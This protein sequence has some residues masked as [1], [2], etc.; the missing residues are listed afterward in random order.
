MD[1]R[2]ILDLYPLPLARGYRR[3]LNASEVKERHDL[4]FCLFEILLKYVAS[5]AIAAYLA[6]EERDH[7]VNAAL[8]G[9]MRPSL[10][11]W[12]RFLRECLEFLVKQE[13]ADPALRAMATLLKEK[14]SH[15]PHVV[16]LWNALRA[17][18]TGSASAKEAASLENVL[19]EIVAYRNRVLGHGAPL[20]R[21]E[22]QSFASLFGPA[23][24]ELLERSPFL[25]ARRLVSFD[26]IH[27]H[28][29]SRVE[30]TV[31]EF[32]GNQ[33]VRRQE[34]HR[35]DYGKAVPQAKLLYLLDDD[36]V[37]VALD[38][39][40]VAHKED[41]YVLNEAQGSPEYLSYASGKRFR[42][43]DLGGKQGELF[44][45]ILGYKVDSSRMSQISDEVAATASEETIPE[46]EHRLGD[47]R[48]LR[49]IGRG[50]MGTVF[51]AFQGSL[52]RRVALK[53]LPGSF[54]L[55]PK[56][57]ERFRREARATA[58]I[59]HPNIV[60][61]YEVGEGQGTHFYAM[62]FIDGPS[63][64]QLL[65]SMRD[66]AA[67]RKEKKGSSTTDPAYIANAVEQVTALAE[68]LQEAH[69]QG[70]VHRDVKPG[71]VLVEKSGRWVLVDFGLVHDAE[72]QTLTRSGEMVGTLTYM[73]PEQISRQ[74]V[75]ARSDVFSLGATLYEVL[76]L[77]PPF[78]GKSDPE[79][80]NAILFDEPVPPRKLNSKI[81]RDLET[82]LLHALEKKPDKRYQ[83]AAEF[84]ADLERFL[85]Y[86]PIAARPRGAITRFVGHTRKHKG[87]ASAAATLALVLVASSLAW[88]YWPEKH[89]VLVNQRRLTSDP[90]LTTEPTLTPDGKLIA[91][92][93]DRADED[94]LD[95]WVQ[96]VDGSSEP[97]R[98]TNHPADDR[99]PAFAPDGKS[100]AFRSERDGGGVYVVSGD[101]IEARLLA[102]NGFRPRYSPDGLQVA[103]WVGDRDLGGYGEIRIVSAQGGESRRLKLPLSS[104]CCPVW[105]PN[106]RQLLFLGYQSWDT[107]ARNRIGLDWWVTSV[108]GKELVRTGVFDQ[109]PELLATPAAPHSWAKVGNRILVSVP[110]RDRDCLWAIEVSATDFKAVGSRPTLTQGTGREIDPYGADGG[111]LAFASVSSKVN[112]WTLP[113]NTNEGRV[114]GS[115]ER[116]THTPA[117]DTR[118]SVTPDGTRVVFA[119]NRSK[120]GGIWLKELPGGRETLLT[121][122][123]TE[124]T[125][126][127]IDQKGSKV[128]FED[129]GTM[130]GLRVRALGE[131]TARTVRDGPGMAYDW[132]EDGREILFFSA[133][134][135]GNSVG[136]LDVPT[137]NATVLLEHPKK[138]VYQ[139]HFSPNGLWIAFSAASQSGDRVRS[140][141]FIT[142]HRKAGPI[143]EEE[144]IPITD[145]WGWDDKPRWSPDGNILYFTSDR[146]GFR[147]IWLQRL[148]PKSKRPIGETEALYHFHSNRRSPMTV[149]LGEL[150]L[151]VAR[152]KIVI[153]LAELTGNI[154]LGELEERR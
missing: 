101:G 56:R 47:Y 32:V 35:I 128:L 25:T 97:R 107:N 29:G 22:Y 117:R 150:E 28:E 133:A 20:E 52:G 102:L 147:C 154:W 41:V 67:K 109:F 149:S 8:K 57:L 112:L 24:S 92:A 120:N 40:L 118:P 4:G 148:E 135:N 124:E 17:L 113:V 6:G 96:P 55:E 16:L 2:K 60:P 86:E 136:L 130:P 100:I 151:S 122:G 94:N 63:L 116:L 145:G 106:G 30:C 64:D 54:A 91:Y 121:T 88:R 126:P 37:F 53:V 90:G 50:G 99:E 3:Y 75:T 43:S 5:V 105:S 39:L 66:E 33:P 138:N 68:G 89:L 82:I 69:R 152:D 73:S 77:K 134:P 142:P 26:S 74:K 13:A 18:R 11:E 15:W 140:E 65:A 139:A 83:S 59:H 143:E 21:D 49:E 14:D 12:V 123:A 45:R 87:K 127:V 7:R 23:F 146:D 51:E 70:L 103:Y 80:H 58:R 10:G 9:L 62:E 27:V 72:A 46:G 36:G 61:V 19:E 85:R 111:Q 131:S 108:D 44:E 81:N 78:E 38:P 42:P 153:N 104:A 95:I 141:L 144:W 98:L 84:S 125:A 93:S 137:G 79:I 119:S 132:S 31:I 110:F 76:T 48:I 129:V 71:N 34:P 115:P 114:T 1:D